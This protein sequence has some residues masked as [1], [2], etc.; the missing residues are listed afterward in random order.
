MPLQPQFQGSHLPQRC[1]FDAGEVRARILEQP[2]DVLR[3]EEPAPPGLGRTEGIPRHG[4]EGLLQLAEGGNRKILLRTVNHT[5][6]CK[7]SSIAGVSTLT[8]RKSGA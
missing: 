2:F 4:A 1:A 7:E 5:S 3:A 8:P 6:F